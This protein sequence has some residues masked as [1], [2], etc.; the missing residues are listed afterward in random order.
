VL[1]RVIAPVATSLR[2]TSCWPFVSPATRLV[3]LLEKATKRPSAEIAALS[4]KPKPPL[5][6]LASAPPASVLTRA[7]APVPRFLTKTSCWPFVSLATRFVAALEKTTWLPS[8]EMTALRAESL[9]GV[10]PSGAVLTRVIAWVR[11][12]LT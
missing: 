4:V 10:T 3:A 1:T 6:S 2:K 9:P 12:S 8:A 5:V 7:R 11:R